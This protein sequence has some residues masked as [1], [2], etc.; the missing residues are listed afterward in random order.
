MNKLH[1]SPKGLKFCGVYV[2]GGA[3]GILIPQ[4]VWI[5]EGQIVSPAEA[6]TCPGPFEMLDARGL[7]LLPALVDLHTTL[8]DPGQEYKETLEQLCDAAVA[9]GYAALVT[10]PAT[11][12]INDHRALTEHLLERARIENRISLLPLAA[13]SD[14]LEHRQL[15]EMGELVEAGVAGFSDGEVPVERTDFLRRAMEY[16]RPLKRPLYLRCE[17]PFLALGGVMHEGFV[18]TTLGLKGIPAAAEELAVHRALVLS[19]LTRCP[20]H[21]T[22]LSTAGSVDLVRQ[23][24]ALGTPVTCDVSAH[25]LFFTDAR[26]RGYGPESKVSPPLRAESDQEALI[27][28]LN[29]GTIDA[30]ASGHSPQ[31]LLEKEVEFEAAG[32]GTSSIETTLPSVVTLV[33]QGKLTLARAID[34]LCIQPA[35]IAGN[36]AGYSVGLPSE[37]QSA[38]HAGRRVVSPETGPGERHPAQAFDRLGGMTPPG[39]DLAAGSRADVI[40]VDPDRVRRVDPLRFRSPS[41]SSLF[42]GLSLQGEVLMTLRAGRIVYRRPVPETHPETSM[43]GTLG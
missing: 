33:K 4:D 43:D 16:L 37:G 36:F 30:V 10:S 39:G 29:D 2:P 34:A 5:W 21:L 35:H 41:R 11:T 28:G 23:F 1:T 7:W 15:S 32:F 6:A 3:G 25:Q 17:D 24:K 8:R 27:H 31:S 42:T 38:G 9:G 26:V 12:P 18:S 40:L 19:R 14:K 13:L 22:R 20:I